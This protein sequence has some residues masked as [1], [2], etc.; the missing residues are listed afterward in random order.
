M[1][2]QEAASQAE[3]GVAANHIDALHEHFDTVLG[4]DVREGPRFD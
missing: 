1:R 3:Y 4:Q 2:A